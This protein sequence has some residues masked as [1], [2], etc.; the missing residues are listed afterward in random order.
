[1]HGLPGLGA[2]METSS[3]QGNVCSLTLGLQC[4]CITTGK[5]DRIRPFVFFIKYFGMQ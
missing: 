3:R 1:M 4:G 5:L 2:V